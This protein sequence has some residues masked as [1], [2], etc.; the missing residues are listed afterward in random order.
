A[1]Q[2]KIANCAGAG[3]E[4]VQQHALTLFDADR[5]TLAEHTSIDRE[6][7]VVKL[8]AFGQA[9]GV[10][11]E[12]WRRLD[13]RLDAICRREKLHPHIGLREKWPEFL[14]RQKQFAVVG[15]RLAPRIYVDR[16]SVV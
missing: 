2:R 8:I 9:L 12:L 16:K 14:Q 7:I 13:Q 4:D 1:R 5:L 11:Q 15:A 10:G 3:V 6:K